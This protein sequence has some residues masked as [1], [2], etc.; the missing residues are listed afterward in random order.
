MPSV[1][2]PPSIF[3]Q[4]YLGSSNGMALL[5]A[6][7]QWL[8][9]NDAMCRIFGLS[10]EELIT[11]KFQDLV[12]PENPMDNMESY[13]ISGT[14]ESELRL[15][16]K[17]RGYIAACIKLTRVQCPDNIPNFF[18]Q[19]T[20]ITERKAAELKYLTLEQQ[21][22]LIAEYSHDIFGISSADEIFRHFSPSITRTLGYSPEELIGKPRSF[23]YHPD[24]LRKLQIS[25]GLGEP[26]QQMRLRHKNGK[27]LWFELIVTLIQDE[28]QNDIYF[29]I[30]REITERKK[31]QHIIAEAH[32]IALIGS[33][34]WDILHDEVSF[35]DQIFHLTNLK[36]ENDTS[37]QITDLV[38]PSS[39]PE[40]ERTIEKSLIQGNDFDFEFQAAQEDR[41]VKHLHIRGV[42]T[43]SNDGHPIKVN[44]TLQDITQRRL[45]ELKLQ[46]TVERY[47]SLKKYNHDAIFS[48]TLEGNIINANVMAQELTGYFIHEMVGMH[49]SR[50]IARKDVKQVLAASLK[51]S[52]AEKLIDKM[53][54][55][56]GHEAEVLTTIAPIIINNE[57]VGFYI[58]AKDITE[59]KKLMIAK[60]TAESTNKAKSEFLAMMSHEI[61]TPMNGVIGMTDLL[62]ESPSLSAEQREYL[63]IIRKSGETLLN[64]I[65]DILDFSKIDSGVTELAEEP[66]D[67]RAC[68]F[69]SV[70]LLSPK[71]QTKQLEVSFS[72]HQDVPPLIYGDSKRLKQVLMNLIGNAI[73]FTDK[74]GI[75]ISVKKLAQADNTVQLMFKV[76]DTGIG[77]PKEKTDQLFQPFYQLD[78]FMTRT[79]EG[80]GL[81]LA[82]SKKLVNL[83]GGNIW[84]DHEDVHEDS[85]GSTFVFT[86]TFKTAGYFDAATQTAAAI[87]QAAPVRNI[88]I[89]VA[90]DNKINQLVLVK[91]LENQGHTIR[92]VEGGNE[93][94]DAALT[95]SF[96]IIFMD[97]H[98]PGI[99]GLEATTIIKDN[100]SPDQCPIIVAVTANAL[101]GDREKC[102]E[103]GMDD[104][105][106][107]PITNQAVNEVI[108]KFFVR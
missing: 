7:G 8:E 76:K 38:D 29:G 92:I 87:E 55:R 41:N 64:I 96:D 39:R 88:K 28:E 86:V 103:A 63:E 66:L 37:Y 108:R 80:T 52:S 43:R 35:S 22:R 100:L 71:A 61:R 84:V 83:M 59:Q 6:D 1:Q 91:M 24:D 102:I 77:I 9:T 13:L 93:V 47:T 105:I 44:G 25:R 68:I 60:E 97:V 34:E 26:P 45:V 31:S 33:W 57:N 79:S 82:I 46:E 95:E 32:R 10:K 12:S 11:Y 104:Y 90:E 50:F 70:D 3:E 69:E 14:F 23:L 27:F 62:M 16:H 17:E 58:I 53:V 81:G 85:P 75:S 49:F 73:K 42:V 48:L 40:F 15:F 18:L 89:L 21:Y 99:N 94:V 101:K 72:M 74:G 98:M 36:C 20:D 51:D 56:D 78:N 54:R 65:N 4:L 5:T 107:K 2:I 19:A 30:A 67:V 106:S